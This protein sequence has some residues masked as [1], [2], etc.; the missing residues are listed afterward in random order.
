MSDRT[1]RSGRNY[2]AKTSAIEKNV[3]ETPTNPL[4]K[5]PVVFPLQLT[6][7]MTAFSQAMPLVPEFSEDSKQLHKC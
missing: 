4:F 7:T 1:S 5:Y 2:T 6:K 3:G